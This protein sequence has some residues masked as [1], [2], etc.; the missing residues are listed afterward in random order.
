MYREKN[1]VVG[2]QTFT[3][4]ALDMALVEKKYS[5]IFFHG[6]VKNICIF[7]LDAAKK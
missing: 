2:S 3:I 5:R 7:P 6:S 1:A 4:S